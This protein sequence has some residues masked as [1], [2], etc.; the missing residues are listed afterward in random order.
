[1]QG[2]LRCDPRGGGEGGGGGD[3]RLPQA[4]SVLRPVPLL[5]CQG[6]SQSLL[7]TTPVRSQVAAV[8]GRAVLLPTV[9]CS[10]PWALGSDLKA[11]P[12]PGS[13]T[14]MPLGKKTVGSFL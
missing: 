3:G 9:P 8:L 2:R 4:S 13:S 1:M 10:A 6:R 7:C 5:C 11:L 12:W 14:W